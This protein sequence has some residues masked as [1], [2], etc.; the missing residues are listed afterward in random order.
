MTQMIMLTNSPQAGQSIK[1]Q[2]ASNVRKRKYDESF[3]QF[4]FTLYKIVTV[5]ERL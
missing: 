4:G 5:I 1:K 2:A 3:L